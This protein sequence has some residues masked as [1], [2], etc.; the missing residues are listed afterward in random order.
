MSGVVGMSARPTVNCRADAIRLSEREAG[1]DGGL[2]PPYESFLQSREN[3]F[4]NTSYW[5]DGISRLV[6]LIRERAASRSRGYLTSE[7]SRRSGSTN[8]PS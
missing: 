4:E 5:S 6:R 8:W 7:V 1:E 3:A 2:H